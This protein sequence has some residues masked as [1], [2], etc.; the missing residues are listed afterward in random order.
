MQE[1]YPIL[2]EACL[3]NGYTRLRKKMGRANSV[4]FRECFPEAIF[5]TRVVL[6]WKLSV[7]SKRFHL[8][9]T[10]GKCSC[11][12]KWPIVVVLPRRTQELFYI[13][14]GTS[15]ITISKGNTLQ[16]SNTLWISNFYTNCECTVPKYLKQ[17]VFPHIQQYIHIHRA[18][19]FILSQIWML[20]YRGVRNLSYTLQLYADGTSL[21]LLKE[22]LKENVSSA[23]I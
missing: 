17:T 23:G 18:N 6:F 4:R 9:Y 2:S 22:F 5:F 20:Y 19:L 1:Q 13:C 12:D 11:Y 7:I 14:A 10:F 16:F 15:I 8:R 3:A 21:R